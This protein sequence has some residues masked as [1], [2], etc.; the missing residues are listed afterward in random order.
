MSGKEPLSEIGYPYSHSMCYSFHLAARDESTDSLAHISA[1]VTSVVEHWLE[2]KV[3]CE[4]FIAV[5][6]PHFF[7][8]FLK[9]YR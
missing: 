9:Y 5:S 2:R 4:R 6:E 8:L 7:S 1:F 3:V